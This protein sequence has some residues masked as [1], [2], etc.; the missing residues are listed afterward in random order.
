[1][2]KQKNMCVLVAFLSPFG[3]LSACAA[4]R[5][6]GTCTQAV[7][8]SPNAGSGM[9]VLFTG[10]YIEIESRDERLPSPHNEVSK[11]SALFELKRSGDSWG[12]HLWTAR[13][14]FKLAPRRIVGAKAHL[15]DRENKVYITNI[16][17]TEAM[18]ATYQRAYSEMGSQAATAGEPL[19]SAL[20]PALTDTFA[21]RV[22]KQITEEKELAQ[23]QSFC[24]SSSDFGSF[25][26]LFVNPNEDAKSL[27]LT[28][29]ASYQK[30]KQNIISRY[31]VDELF[32]QTMAQWSSLI[33]EGREIQMSKQAMRFFDAVTYGCKQP[34]EIPQEPEY[35]RT[36]FEVFQKTMVGSCG[37]LSLLRSVGKKYVKT[38]EGLDV[39]MY[40]ER[41]G[42]DV[43][44][45]NYLEKEIEVPSRQNLDNLRLLWKELHPQISVS[46]I[47]VH[48]NVSMSNGGKD[49]LGYT[50]LPISA[51][52]KSPVEPTFS[53]SGVPR[54]S[55]VTPKNNVRIRFVKG[56]S[57]T[58]ISVAGLS[59]ILFLSTINAD[60]TSE[61]AALMPLPVPRQKTV[62]APV[63]IEKAPET[64]PASTT[65]GSS[66][67]VVAG[68]SSVLQ[69]LTERRAT[70]APAYGSGASLT[71]GQPLPTGG[72]APTGGPAEMTQVA[73]VP[74]Q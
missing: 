10:G 7:A 37:A 73:S 54:F 53:D 48:A 15:Y 45:V 57:G 28:E 44:G 52:V 71:V 14:C 38:R 21:C 61:G 8:L 40:A 18:I 60:E 24:G 9:D 46:A 36:R 31:G 64:Q 33:E 69:A 32:L 30:R 50:S 26:I 3:A 34:W 72:E 11:C 66:V 47:G 27:I 20:L 74:C 1:M 12:A 13:H 16:P 51:L 6:S 59:P 23:K 67:A 55:F 19:L 58:I 39:F 35:K 65:S 62:S 2:K 41:V 5:P 56:D 4:K 17:F 29:L 25:D 42:I 63:A 68:L 70:Q 49:V 22:E 43:A